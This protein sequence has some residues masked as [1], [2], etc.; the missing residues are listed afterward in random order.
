MTD[1]GRYDDVDDLRSQS[2]RRVWEDFVDIFYAPSHVFARRQN[3]SFWIPMLVVT[4][5]V[6]TV[7]FLTSGAM[8]PIIDAE[9]NRQ[10]AAAMRKNPRITPEAMERFRNIATRIGQVMVFVVDADHHRDDRNNAVARWQAVRRTPD[11]QSRA[12][13]R[14]ILL[15]AESASRP[16]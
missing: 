10:A 1:D 15:R 13:R 6:G 3:G 7:Y 16:S 9:F 5:L 2:G 14:G 4:L 11:I 12:D 8:Q